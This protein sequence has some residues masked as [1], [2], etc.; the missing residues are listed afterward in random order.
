MTSLS[1]NSS[2]GKAESSNSNSSHG[3]DESFE[4]ED[5]TSMCN[6][7]PSSVRSSS[8]PP[9]L[10]TQQPITK[11]LTSIHNNNNNNSDS[12]K[13]STSTNDEERG[14]PR[15][16]ND[17]PIPT[18]ATTTAAPTGSEHPSHP[19]NESFQHVLTRRRLQH[20]ISLLSLHRGEVPPPRPLSLYQIELHKL[21]P[22]KG[23]NTSL[24]HLTYDPLHILFKIKSKSLNFE[25]NTTT[26]PHNRIIQ[27]NTIIFIL[28]NIKVT[29]EFLIIFYYKSFHKK[30]TLFYCWLHTAFIY[31]NEVKLFKFELDKSHKDKNHKKFPKDFYLSLF[32]KEENEK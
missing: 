30:N 19:S 24:F 12:N 28:P 9:P 22:C 14:S 16:D 25:L 5:S 3:K 23:S 31:E 4:V 7:I 15:Y 32:C 21:F 1:P 8:F 10:L 13:P 17:H 2:V 18:T 27:N 6:H 11:L 26:T 29:D 20:N